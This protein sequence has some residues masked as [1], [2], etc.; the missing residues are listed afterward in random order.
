MR[1]HLQLIGR[2]LAFMVDSTTRSMIW[3]GAKQS[4]WPVEA[5]RAEVDKLNRAA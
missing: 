2:N 1:Y 4:F 5:A 3:F